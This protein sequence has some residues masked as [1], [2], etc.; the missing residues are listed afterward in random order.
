M[1]LGELIAPKQ[2]KKKLFANV[3]QNR[4]DLRN[5]SCIFDKVW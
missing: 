5:G 2:Q 4:H 3:Y 1:Q